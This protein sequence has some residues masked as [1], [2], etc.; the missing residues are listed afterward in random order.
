METSTD[1]SHRGFLKLM[2]RLP[3]L[4][5]DLRVFWPRD[6]SIQALCEA[7]DQ[8]TVMF[9]R[10][11]ATSDIDDETLIEEYRILCAQLE[12]D[13]IETCVSR[14]KGST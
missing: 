7:Y 11:V 5:S 9:E 3:E 13:V 1:A 14:H 8:A 6:P 2:L 12:G 4:R 10:L